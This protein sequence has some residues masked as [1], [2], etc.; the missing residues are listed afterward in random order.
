VI[1]E[2][3]IVEEDTVGD[4]GIVQTCVILVEDIVEKDMVEDTVEDKDIAEEDIVQTGVIL[5]EDTLGDKGFVEED[6]GHTYMEECYHFFRVTLVIL[7]GLEVAFLKWL[8]LEA[9]EVVEVDQ[10]VV[11]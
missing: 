9:V 3:D 2:E 8:F 4:K 1:L 7:E 6:I 10:N 5:V 11:V